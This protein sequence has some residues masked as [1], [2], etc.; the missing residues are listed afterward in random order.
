MIKSAKNFPL[1]GVLNVND[2]WE[3][4]LAYNEKGV[5]NYSI[6]LAESDSFFKMSW[7]EWTVVTG[8]P[9]SGKSD[10]VDQIFCNV[11][12]K[13]GFRC[14]MF[15]PESFPYTFG[16][17]GVHFFRNYVFRFLLKHNTARPTAIVAIVKSG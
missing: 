12:T 14:A 2:I 1:E 5:Q 7:G 11:A 6:G 9:N 10:I 13:Y 15:A 17:V 3:N 16:H 4:V 8:V